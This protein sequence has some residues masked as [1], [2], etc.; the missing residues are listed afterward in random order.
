MKVLVTGA[1][2]QLGREVMK[3]LVLKG[4]EAA[5]TVFTGDGPAFTPDGRDS[6][7]PVYYAM[8]VTDRGAVFSV[9]R[10]ARPDAVIHCAAR[11]DVDAA[12]AAENREAARRVN[13]EGTENVAEAAESVGAK[14][15]YI[16]TDYV[17][18][19]EGDVP[20]KPEETR[21]AP[22]NYYG[23]TKL[24]GERAVAERA[25]RFFIVRISWLFGTG[26]KNFIK[27]MIGAGRSHDAVR[28]VNDQFGTPTYAKDLAGL[29]TEMIVT[30]KYG[31][32][33]ATN[34]EVTPGGYISWYD[35]TKEIYRLTGLDTEVIP[36]STE[37]Y[38]L[39][40]AARPFNSR[41]DKA[42]LPE[43][44]FTP[45]PDWKD[46]LKRYLEEEEGSSQ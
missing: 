18:G 17:F 41:L 36:V 8:D 27:T 21:F 28:V 46:A 24:E 6:D 40:K 1:A 11:T 44:G 31:Y 5:G 3:T 30:E 7:P 25:D 20:W 38:G 22:L 29:L 4:F 26:G 32:Y 9:F 35:L 23:M 12:E 19:G 13:A 16:S 14:L 43:A 39:S 2:G 45:L 34:S 42:G 15:V 33:H 37:E 10:R